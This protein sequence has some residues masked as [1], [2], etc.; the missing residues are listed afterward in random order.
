MKPLPHRHLTLLA[1][2]FFITMG[3]DNL[4]AYSW[5]D[6]GRGHTGM[7]DGGRGHTGMSE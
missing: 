7:S 4:A 2:I 1:H 5:R 6:G 3:I